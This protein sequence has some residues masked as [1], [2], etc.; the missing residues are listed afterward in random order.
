MG[1]VDRQW[2]DRGVEEVGKNKRKKED[3][4]LGVA[5]RFCSVVLVDYNNL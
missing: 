3:K 4:T 2:D 5:S 1:E